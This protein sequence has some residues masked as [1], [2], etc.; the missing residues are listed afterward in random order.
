[1]IIMGESIV[2]TVSFNPNGD[3]LVFIGINILVLKGLDNTVVKPIVS[4]EEFFYN[5]HDLTYRILPT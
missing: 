5:R 1:M 2:Y 4:D 3:D